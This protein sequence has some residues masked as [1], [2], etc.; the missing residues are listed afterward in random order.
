MKREVG[1]IWSFVELVERAALEQQA[2]IDAH[3]AAFE[4]A[5]AL[6]NS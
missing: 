1:D 2:D 3:I 5:R 4:R 6:I